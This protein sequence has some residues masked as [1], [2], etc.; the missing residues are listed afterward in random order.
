M[1]SFR[2]NID[3]LSIPG[4][5]ALQMNDGTAEKPVMRNY[6]CIPADLNEIKIEAS[7]NDQ[8][9]LT[10]YM[11]LMMRPFGQAYIN[12]V[13]DNKQRRGDAVDMSKIESHEI[14]VNH[15]QEFI[16]AWKGAVAQA[17][18][19]EHPEWNGQSLDKLPDGKYSDLYYEV[20]RR[21]NKRVGKG[22]PV[23]AQSQ[24]QV[25]SVPVNSFGM[26]QGVAPFDP[27]NEPAPQMA[28][29]G[30]APVDDLPF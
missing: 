8:T 13:V 10:A 12:S 15:T 26:A 22:Y 14:T 5:K 21:I 11:N 20:R 7:R 24:Q 18:L 6:I 25:Q 19:K 4:A 1:A 3:L 28:A 2:P 27:N 16:D 17:V 9:K 30:E 29:P 23:M